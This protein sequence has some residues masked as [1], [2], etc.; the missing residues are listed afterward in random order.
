LTELPGIE[1]KEASDAFGE[2]PKDL[3]E[4]SLSGKADFGG[5]VG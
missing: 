4:E 2:N 1:I 5:G 3:V